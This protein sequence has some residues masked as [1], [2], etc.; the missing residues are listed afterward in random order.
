MNSLRLGCFLGSLA[1]TARARFVGFNVCLTEICFLGGIHA[2]LLD[3]FGFL[4][5]VHWWLLDILCFQVIPHVP[6]G[7][8]M[9]SKHCSLV[10]ARPSL[11]WGF[12]FF[13]S[14]KGQYCRHSYK[15]RNC[16]KFMLFISRMLWVAYMLSI[17]SLLITPY[18]VS[19]QYIP[20]ALINLIAVLHRLDLP[21]AGSFWYFTAFVYSSCCTFFSYVS[22]RYSWEWVGFSYFPF[23]Q[24]SWEHY[25]VTT[26]AVCFGVIDKQLSSSVCG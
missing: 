24:L 22:F 20:L 16:K 6:V 14:K 25:A 8:S 18:A 5:I 4:V 17:S 13:Q 2:C 12:L 1:M 11:W 23:F 10:P 15:Y 9:C 19:S 26:L 3:I 21:R 7:P